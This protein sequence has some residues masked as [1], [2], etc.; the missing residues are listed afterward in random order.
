MYVLF[1]LLSF[2]F[3]M[4]LFP[5]YLFSL[6]TYFDCAD[7]DSYIVTQNCYHFL[8]LCTYF[9]GTYFHY[10]LILTVPTATPT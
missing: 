2:S 8:F 5:M 1:E 3:P 4:Y 10:V 7:C 6:C 9:L